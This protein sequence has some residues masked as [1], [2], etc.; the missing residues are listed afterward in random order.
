MAPVVP[1]TKLVEGPTKL[2]PIE[3][4]AEYLVKRNMPV[5]AGDKVEDYIHDGLTCRAKLAMS[6]T[7]K[8]SIIDWVA[9]QKAA[10]PK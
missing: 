1:K 6:N 5:L 10:H 7:D 3:P 4:P 8:Q 2:I 9:K